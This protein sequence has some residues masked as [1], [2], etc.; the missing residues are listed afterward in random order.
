MERL[1]LD[2]N[3]LFSAAW[4]CG[5]LVRALFELDDVERV[6]SPAVVQEAHAA[7][8]RFSAA[9]GLAVILLKVAVVD[10]ASYGAIP[11]GAHRLAEK[12]LH[13]LAAALGCGATHLITGDVKHFGSLMGRADF[14]IRVMVPRQYIDQRGGR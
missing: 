5:G 14:P 11:A 1:F 3:V 10:S 13:V 6:T 9:D 7:L 2:A 4:R 12:D 8:A